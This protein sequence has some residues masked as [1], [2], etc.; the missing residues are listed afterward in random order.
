LFHIVLIALAGLL[1]ILAWSL[2][3]SAPPVLSMVLPRR[4]TYSIG[5]GFF[6]VAIFCAYLAAYA[7]RDPMDMLHCFVQGYVG[8]WFML[9]TSAGHRGSE[10]DAQMLRRLFIMLGLMTGSI[11]LSL[12]L[13]S[14]QAMATLNLAL[15]TGGF[16]VTTNYFRFLD[17]GR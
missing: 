3:Q 14:D 15:I 12:Y 2:V 8:L 13:R 7:L 16:W 10:G 5:L 11:T 4:L 1:L 6:I 9:A 17:R